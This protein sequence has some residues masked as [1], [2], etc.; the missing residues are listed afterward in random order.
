GRHG[1]IEATVVEFRGAGDDR[2]GEVVDARLP[3]GGAGGGVDRVG[4]AG[5]IAEE[6]GP[7]VAE[8]AESDRGADGGRRFKGPVG[9]AGGGIEGVDAEDGAADE[10]AA[11]GDGGLG[12]G[13]GGVREGE[14]PFQLQARRFGGGEARHGG[15]L[16]T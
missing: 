3:D 6:G 16:E 1:D 5:L 14:G 8:F 15:G 7:S 2:A 11:G 4:I 12:V 9:A 10:N 13:S